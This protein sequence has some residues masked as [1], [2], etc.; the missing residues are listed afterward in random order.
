MR[1]QHRCEKVFGASKACFVACPT[2]DSLEPL[3]ALLEAKLA[4]HGIE[5]VVAVKERAYGQDIVC[6][7][8]CGRIIESRFCVAILDEVERDGASLANPNVYYEYGL[9]T[10]LR[11]HVIPLQRDG[12]ALA[13]N[14]QSQD[15]IK[16]NDR[17]MA[18]ELERAIR[19]AITQTEPGQQ[20]EGSDLPITARGIRRRLELAGYVPGDRNLLANGASEDTQ[21]LTFESQDHGYLFLA[22]LDDARDVANYSDDLPVLVFR[23]DDLLRRTEA[24]LHDLPAKIARLKEDIPT[25]DDTYG[26]ARRAFDLKSELEKAERRAPTLERRIQNLTTAHLGFVAAPDLDH[27]ALRARTE[28]A[29]ADTPITPIWNDGTILIIGESVVEL[30]RVPKDYPAEDEGAVS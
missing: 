14:I 30:C 24:E 21:F 2:D 29:L 18:D 25:G 1:R 3:L 13:F 17:N 8:I 4:A 19:D 27:A 28:A 22:K 16:Y 9:M 26:A 7:K 20:A 23:L 6:T 5:A 12:M 10:A 11:K 15:T